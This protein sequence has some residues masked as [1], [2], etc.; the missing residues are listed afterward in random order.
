MKP[1]PS[2]SP[3]RYG[4]YAGLLISGVVLLYAISLIITGSHHLIP[5]KAT[6]AIAGIVQALTCWYALQGNRTAWSFAVA[7]D[8][9][10]TVAFIFG[11]PNLRDAWDVSLPLGF[12]PALILGATTVL[13]AWPSEQTRE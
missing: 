12:V 8:G 10:V 7:L 5:Y 4:C 13:L 1:I 9:V 3:I 2:D 11:A 6:F